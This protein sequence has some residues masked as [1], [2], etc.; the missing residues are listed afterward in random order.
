MQRT[1]PSAPLALCDDGD[2]LRR[3]LPTEA[4]AGICLL[5]G[6]LEEAPEHSIEFTRLW[7]LA[8]YDQGEVWGLCNLGVIVAKRG[9]IPA[10]KALTEQAREVAVPTGNPTMM[11]LIYYSDGESLLEVDPVHALEPIGEALAFARAAD[12]VFMTGNALV[13]NTSLRGRHGDPALALPLFEEVIEYWRRSGGWTQLWLTLRNLVELISRLGAYE[14]AAVLYGACAAFNRSLSPVRPGGGPA[15]GGRA[16][17][18]RRARTRRVRSC[19]AARRTPRRRRLRRLRLRGDTA[20]PA[21][22]NSGAHAGRKRDARVIPH[23][24]R[25]V[26]Q[27]KGATP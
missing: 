21:H 2:D 18:D 20:P 22:L 7:R 27:R 26:V 9:D 5:S 19:H 3:A 15:A 6:R 12:N 16:N 8:G 14:E 11:A 4:L 24:Q 23:A 10:A 13:S 25:T 17:P 1:T